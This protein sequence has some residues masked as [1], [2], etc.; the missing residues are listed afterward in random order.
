[1]IG[2]PPPRLLSEHAYLV[3]IATGVTDPNAYG[4]ANKG[5]RLLA[6]YGNFI[7]HRL[8]WNAKNDTTHYFVAHT[9]AVAETMLHFASSARHSTRQLIDHHELMLQMPEPTQRARDPFCL[10]VVVPYRG[11]NISIPAIPDRLFSLIYDN[12]TRHN[13]AL[14]LDRG[15]M[16]IWSNRLLGKSSFRRK[17]IAYTNAREQRR[18][19]QAWGFDSLRVLTV[20]MSEERISNMIETQRRVA[21]DC[22]PGFFLYSTLERIER[23][24]ALGP[25]WITSKSYGVSLTSTNRSTSSPPVAPQSIDDIAPSLRAAGVK[26]ALTG[27]DSARA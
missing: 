20:T 9:L 5:A 11:Q 1:V 13:F 8:D 25:A 21:P 3:R 10:R 24:G 7:D 4:L 18:H 17:L 6:E 19:T 2:A 23:H 26:P 12:G 14:E 22:P 15:T 16:D 27:M